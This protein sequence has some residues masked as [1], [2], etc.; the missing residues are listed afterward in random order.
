MHGILHKRHQ[1]THLHSRFCHL[2]RADPNN[3]HL[4]TGH[5]QCHDWVHEGHRAS[6]TTHVFSNVL[7]S[8]VKAFYFKTLLVEGAHNQYTREVL[9]HNQIQAVNQSL[10]A[11]KAWGNQRKDQDDEQDQN[12]NSQRNRPPHIRAFI[13]STHNTQNAEQ[14]GLNSH[15]NGHKGDHLHLRHIV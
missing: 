12:D 4:Y 10:H 2:M 3:E 9:A 7:I 13:H 11:F 1:I 6:D 8:L 14:R 15:A 5:H